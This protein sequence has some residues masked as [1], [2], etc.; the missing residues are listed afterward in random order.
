M[1]ALKAKAKSKSETTLVMT[2]A[3]DSVTSAKHG[4]DSVKT[5][6]K[7]TKDNAS[8]DKVV[9][10]TERTNETTATSVFS[11]SSQDE[12]IQIDEI[13]D[14]AML[15]ALDEAENRQLYSGQEMDAT[16]ASKPDHNQVFTKSMDFEMDLKQESKIENE[17]SDNGR[18]AP[19]DETN[20]NTVSDD[21]SA[22]D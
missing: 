17:K 1:T 3:N 7:E 8:N 14:E 15:Q 16:H 5:P 20:D 13:S 21:S 4:F 10:K 18:D 19:K 9:V 6:E 22:N 12:A 2:T 11:D